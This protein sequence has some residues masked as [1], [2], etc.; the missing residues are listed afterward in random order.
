MRG[1]RAHREETRGCNADIQESSEV[2]Q[3]LR[4]VLA[5]SDVASSSVEALRG[6]PAQV[7]IVR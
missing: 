2:S 1:A 6:T 5:E 4:V 3:L 7:S